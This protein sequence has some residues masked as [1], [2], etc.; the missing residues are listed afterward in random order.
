MCVIIDENLSSVVITSDH[1]L[2]V[3]L[4]TLQ[5]CGL[6]FMG[7]ISKRSLIYYT[8]SYINRTVECYQHCKIIALRRDNV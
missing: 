8:N 5:S 3:V 2:D 4:P 6:Y 1:I 7:T